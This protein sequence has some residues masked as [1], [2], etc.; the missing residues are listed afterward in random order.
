MYLGVNSTDLQDQLLKVRNIELTDCINR[1]KLHENAVVHSKELRSE[2]EAV[3][4][5]GARPKTRRTKLD[6]DTVN[7]KE[8][9]NCKFCNTRHRMQRELCPAY[10]KICS[11]CK[12]KDHFAVKCIA[13]RRRVQAVLMSQDRNDELS[14]GSDY[15]I[16]DSVS[17]T[18]DIENV[19]GVANKLIKAEMLVD[20]KPVTFQ[21]DSGASINLLNRKHIGKEKI[22]PSTKTLVM[23]NGSKM[24]P[25]G[26]CRVKVINPKNGD[27]FAVNFVIV[28]EDL[29]PLL[30]ATAIQ[31]MRLIT[32][33]KDNFEM[34]AKVS[35]DLP[36]VEEFTDVFKDELGSLPGVV[37]L[38][39]D[40]TVTP[41]VA[42]TRR[43]PIALKSCL[44]T[45]LERLVKQ[46]IIEPVVNPTRWVSALALVVK[47][48]G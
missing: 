44:K 34:V 48:N 20:K 47:P 15:E 32:V 10:G 2:S 14:S 24:A 38:N 39:V 30:G 5:V 23:W 8:V 22:Q 12:G 16:V 1:C 3:H 13:S 41:N 37:H 21:L 33:N 25:L 29:H 45:E 36:I 7:D 43:V 18:G 35:H 19:C 42:A 27:K 6:E 17:S 28:H 11:K 4:K 31:Q 26:E 46:G 40:K 9:Q